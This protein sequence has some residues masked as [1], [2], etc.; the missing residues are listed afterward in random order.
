MKAVKNALWVAS[1]EE[2]QT[3]EQHRKVHAVTAMLQS[4]QYFPSM[5]FIRCRDR[6][7]H[8]ARLDIA[9]K[10]TVKPATVTAADVDLKPTD[11]APTTSI[12][13]LVVAHGAPLMQR[14][15]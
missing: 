8:R 6:T 3:P 2:E 5:T 10:M 11:A 1:I 13:E 7:F 15:T 9:W 14:V 12:Q 4:G